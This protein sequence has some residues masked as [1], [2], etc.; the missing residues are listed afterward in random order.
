[1]VCSKRTT[2]LKVI[3]TAIA[4]LVLCSRIVDAESYLPDDLYTL[5]ELMSAAN[6]HRSHRHHRDKRFIWMTEE[7]R[8]VLPP[9]TQ[10]V[11]TPTLAMPLIR[12]P[13]HGMDANLTISTPFTGRTIIFTSKGA[14]WFEIHS[15]LL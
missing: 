15:V 4:V 12:Y 13:P 11:L 2:V 1:M 8:L 9:G 3:W 5:E 6:A 10:L 14:S 7:K